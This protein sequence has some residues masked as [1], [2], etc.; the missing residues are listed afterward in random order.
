[1]FSLQYASTSA[2]RSGLRPVRRRYSS[3]TWSTGKNPHVAPYS[4]DMFPIVAR[5]AS[6]SAARPSPK[7]STNLPTTPARRRISVTVSTRSV[8]VAPSG[9]APL[10]LK[11]TTCSTSIESGWPSI[12]ASASI[13]HDPGQVLE[14]HLM[15]DPGARRDDLEAAERLLPPAQEEV[16]LVVPLVLE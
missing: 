10:S 15:T 1:M 13:L 2:I 3:V 16:P 12:A 5:S 9:S 6:G 8:A 11:P 4:G 7:Y 14:V